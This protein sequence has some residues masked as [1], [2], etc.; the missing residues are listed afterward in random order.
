MNEPGKGKPQQQSW[1][2]LYIY[3][4]IYIYIYIYVCVY[5]YIYT[6]THIYVCSLL[7]FI[8][9]VTTIF[10]CSSTP[11]HSVHT[12]TSVV[13]WQTAV[14]LVAEGAVPH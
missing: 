2:P 10:D 4:C 1:N 11:C 7:P 5:I 12:Q 6:H 13:S 9:D 14:L 3:I 8:S